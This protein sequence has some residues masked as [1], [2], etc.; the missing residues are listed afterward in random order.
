[1][2][3]SQLKKNVKTY[4][5]NAIELKKKREEHEPTKIFLENSER[6]CCNMVL[7]LL[8]RLFRVINLAVFKYFLPYFVILF[9]YWMPA[10][11][12]GRQGENL[13]ATDD[14]VAG[15]TLLLG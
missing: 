9:S 1:M 11:L 14:S 15:Q 8:Y 4:L 10:I 2:L 3:T 12:Y 5:H 7:Y 13:V 6:T